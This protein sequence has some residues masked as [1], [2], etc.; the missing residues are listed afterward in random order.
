MPLSIIG[1]FDK[2]FVEELNTLSDL[3]NIE[4]HRTGRQYG[5]NHRKYLRRLRRVTGHRYANYH[6]NT[7]YGIYTREK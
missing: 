4:I 5:N 3:A 2:F 7:S 6:R 1:E